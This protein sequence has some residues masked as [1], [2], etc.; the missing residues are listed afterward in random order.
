MISGAGPV[1][2]NAACPV[3]VD[4]HRPSPLPPQ[5]GLREVHLPDSPRPARSRLDV[6]RAALHH[7]KVMA[8]EYMSQE[9]NIVVYV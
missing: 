9:Q 8:A 7:V 5:T 3:C 2:R 4:H 6:L 1:S